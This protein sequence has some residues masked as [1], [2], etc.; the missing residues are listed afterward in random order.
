MRRE[1]TSKCRQNQIH[2]GLQLLYFQS[3]LTLATMGVGFLGLDFTAGIVFVGAYFPHGTFYFI[4]KVLLFLLILYAMFSQIACISM[5]MALHFI[6]DYYLI[7]FC[8]REL[9]IGAHYSAYRS[10]NKLRSNGMELRHV[11]RSFQVLHQYQIRLVGPYLVIINALNM[12][13]SFYNIFVLIRYGKV[14]NNLTKMLL[15][16]GV[17]LVIIIWSLVLFAG[18]ML[19]CKGKSVIRSW[20]HKNWDSPLENK[21]MGKFG[22]S[23]QPLVWRHGSMYIMRN[24]N[25]MVFYRGVV[26]GTIRALLMTK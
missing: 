21:V 9:R 5:V 7:V 2:D 19:Y 8:L 14:L 18:K 6:Y 22:N 16:L 1:N 10:N 11:F 26:K 23:C 15:L 17:V 24:P 3:M 13:A 12:I 25:L 20:K 4:L